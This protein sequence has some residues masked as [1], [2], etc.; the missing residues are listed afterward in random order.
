MISSLF[1]ATRLL[2]VRRIH[3][4]PLVTT[5]YSFATTKKKEDA[6]KRLKVS[7]NPAKEPKRKRASINGYYITTKEEKLLKLHPDPKGPHRPAG[8]YAIFVKDFFE[9]HK[10]KDGET[11]KMTEVSKSAADKWNKMSDRQKEPFKAK[12]EKV[13]AHYEKVKEKYTEEDKEAWLNILN[14]HFE[15][16]TTTFF[17]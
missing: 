7:D 6:P 10:P 1:S 15:K 12:H 14:A 16:K 11:V 8:P 13:A 4:F 9:K 5:R 17:I 2:A 3:A